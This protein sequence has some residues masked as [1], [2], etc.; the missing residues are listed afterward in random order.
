MMWQKLLI[1]FAA[2]ILLAL[3]ILL[4]WWWRSAMT[5]AEALAQL[6]SL[7]IEIVLLPGRL[8]RMAT[9][10]RVSPRTRWWMIGL[11]LY[12]ASPIDLIPD[13]IP[14]IGFAD[15]LVIVPLVLWHIRRMI[16]PEVWLEYF[17]PRQRPQMAQAERKGDPESE[18]PRSVGSD[19]IPR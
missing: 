4:I 2:A 10:Q 9:D 5:R 8:R 17:P 13:F 19:A 14:V 15:E 16:P 1:A 18:E 11:A 7:G 3:L 12:I 6:R